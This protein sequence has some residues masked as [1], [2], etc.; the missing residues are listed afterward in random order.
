[1]GEFDSF[2][3]KPARSSE[4]PSIRIHRMQTYVPLSIKSG[5]F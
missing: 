5:A 2:E 1:M 3:E 4:E